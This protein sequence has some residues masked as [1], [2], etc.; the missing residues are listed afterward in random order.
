M[1][2][3]QP[4]KRIGPGTLAVV[5]PG[6]RSATRSAARQAPCTDF[7]H[8]LMSVELGRSGPFV[9]EMQFGV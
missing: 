3:A 6:A 9:P 5:D 2:A 7:W 8:F 1:V 4:F